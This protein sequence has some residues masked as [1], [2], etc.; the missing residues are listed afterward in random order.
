M[1]VQWDCGR[2]IQSEGFFKLH[3][4]GFDMCRDSNGET[5]LELMV[6]YI[7]KLQHSFSGRFR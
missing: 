6:G 4:G 1:H 3:C 7:I 5:D 2:E